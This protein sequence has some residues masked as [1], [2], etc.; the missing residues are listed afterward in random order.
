MT[1][2]HPR[3][4]LAAFAALAVLFAQAA[5]GDVFDGGVPADAGVADVGAGGGAADVGAG[6]GVVD[7]D[8][9]LPPPP[10]SE[11][12]TPPELA[13]TTTATVTTTPLID[14]PTPEQAEP[15][16]PITRRLWFWMAVTGLIVTG[17][18]IGI[19]VQSPNVNRPGCPPGYVCPL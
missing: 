10:P 12:A 14:T 7:V 9:G 1:P 3:S 8:A 17:V 18:A 5:R 15:P 13:P 16:R 6:G 2:L 4:C 19:A 11:I